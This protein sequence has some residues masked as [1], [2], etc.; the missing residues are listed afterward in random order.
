MVVAAYPNIDDQIAV[1]AKGKAAMPA[2][3]LSLSPDQI[4]SVVEFTRSIPVDAPGGTGL[5]TGPIVDGQEVYR[6]TCSGCHDDDGRGSYANNV[7]FVG[8]SMK[9]TYPNIEDEVKTVVKG[10]GDMP[11]YE[12]KLSP[13]EIQAVVDYTRNNL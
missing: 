9:T 3:G 7:S 1:V 12:T 5:A 2:F 11:G 13:A 8:G 10:K 4:R 6:V